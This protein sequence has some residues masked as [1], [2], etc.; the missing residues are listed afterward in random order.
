MAEHWQMPRAF[1]QELGCSESVLQGRTEGCHRQRECCHSGKSEPCCTVPE[2]TH[3]PPVLHLLSLHQP[4]VQRSAGES[5]IQRTQSPFAAQKFEQIAAG[6]IHKICQACRH[7]GQV[8]Y[9]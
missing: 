4:G 8:Q 6:H 3:Q 9:E 1:A 2:V 7:P 5:P